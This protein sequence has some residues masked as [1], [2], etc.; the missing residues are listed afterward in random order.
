M[1]PGDEQ[2]PP[3]GQYLDLHSVS[4]GS[5]FFN[6]EQLFLNA[7]V[8]NVITFRLNLSEVFQFVPFTLQTIL[9]VLHHISKLRFGV[10]NEP[11]EHN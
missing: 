5:H 2:K 11:V 6:E 1:K 7:L 3:R 10:S 8:P 4:I 9:T